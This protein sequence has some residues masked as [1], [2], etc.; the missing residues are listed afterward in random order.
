MH[1]VRSRKTAEEVEQMRRAIAITGK[2]FERCAASR[3]PE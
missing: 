3:S 2:A 1:R